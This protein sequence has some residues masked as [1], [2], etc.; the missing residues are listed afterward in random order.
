[1]Q[2]ITYD[3]LNTIVNRVF[4]NFKVVNRITKL[5]CGSIVWSEKPVWEWGNDSRVKL[6]KWVKSSETINLQ[7]KCWG[8]ELN[9]GYQETK[10]NSSV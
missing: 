6:I 8:K 3:L 10:L 9:Y 7:P 5:Q 1:M 4:S 2:F